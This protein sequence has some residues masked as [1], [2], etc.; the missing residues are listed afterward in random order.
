MTRFD[1]ERRS[2]LWGRLADSLGCRCANALNMGHLNAAAILAHRYRGA[3]E[4]QDECWFMATSDLVHECP[5]EDCPHCAGDAC[6]LC[7][8]RRRGRC[9]HDVLDGH[10]DKMPGCY[11]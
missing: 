11:V 5:G 8:E 6:M 10:G 9:A 4:R 7:G 1:Y 2:S 3:R